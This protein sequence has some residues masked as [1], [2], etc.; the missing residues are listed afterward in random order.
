MVLDI[1]FMILNIL[2]LDFFLQISWIQNKLKGAIIKKIIENINWC[3][4]II[5]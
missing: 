2:K 1:D 5:F 4:F 3:N